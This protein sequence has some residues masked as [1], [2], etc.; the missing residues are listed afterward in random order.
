MQV[1][2]Q[3]QDSGRLKLAVDTERVGTI[4]VVDVSEKRGILLSLPLIEPRTARLIAWTLNR[5][6]HPLN[7]CGCS[8]N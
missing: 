7:K 4:V 1:S 3:I 5:L 6:R 2:G 8:S